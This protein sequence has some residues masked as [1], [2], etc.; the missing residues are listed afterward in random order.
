MRIAVIPAR[1]GS[2]RIPGKNIRSFCGQPMIA[3]SIRR[4]LDSGCFD[5]IVVSTD[6]PDIAA[7]AEGCGATV[8]FLRPAELSDD[9]TGT[10]PVVAHA[11]ESLRANGVRPVAVCCIYATAPFL[12][13]EDVRAGA[14]K[15]AESGCDFVFS[16]T[17]YAFPIQRALRITSAGRIEMFEPGQFQTRSQDL[18]PAFHDAAQFYWGRTDAWLEQRPIFADRSIPL[19]LPRERVQDIDTPEDW[20]RAELMF[21]VLKL[22]PGVP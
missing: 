13:S 18:E 3:W 21:E 22:R 11:I 2:K 16:V 4:A 20:K 19:I 9:H 5:D 15:L 17:G 1:G 6:S 8:P 12:R 7:I 10:L 14:Q